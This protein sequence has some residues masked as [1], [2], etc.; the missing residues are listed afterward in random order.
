MLTTTESR[1][2]PQATKA[3]AS[4]TKHLC[5]APTSRN[6][7]EDAKTPPTN[8]ATNTNSQENVPLHRHHGEQVQHHGQRD[9]ANPMYVQT[10]RFSIQYTDHVVRK[11]PTSMARRKNY[12][13]ALLFLS[14]VVPGLSTVTPQNGETTAMLGP[15][16]APTSGPVS[17]LSHPF[18]PYH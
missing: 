14:C 11:T 7:V 9:V 15:T 1:R 17:Q 16:R 4:T 2:V 3:C 5:P 12:W 6:V 18:E 8:E 13:I 10:L